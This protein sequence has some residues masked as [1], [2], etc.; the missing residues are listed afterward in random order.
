MLT[1]LTIMLISRFRK[2]QFRRELKWQDA[3]REKGIGFRT[4]IERI[5]E[6]N[7]LVNGYRKIVFESKVRIKGKTVC[8]KMH[9]LSG[10]NEALCIGDKVLIRYHPGHVAHVLIKKIG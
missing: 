1:L 8:R 10:I 5:T 3:L 7:V 6:N 9:T 2:W 4:A